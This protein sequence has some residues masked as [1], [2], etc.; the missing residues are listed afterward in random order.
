MGMISEL[1]DRKAGLSQ[2]RHYL[3][4]ILPVNVLNLVN[5]ECLLDTS[6]HFSGSFLVLEG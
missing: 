6:K 2:T 1:D 3:R 4:P 5:S